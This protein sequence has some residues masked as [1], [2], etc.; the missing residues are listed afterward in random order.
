MNARNTHLSIHFV[1]GSLAV[2]LLF[3]ESTEA[4][5]KNIWLN[6]KILKQS[7]LDSTVRLKKKRS[8]IRWTH[9]RFAE[10]CGCSYSFTGW[11]DVNTVLLNCNVCWLSAEFNVRT[12]SALVNVWNMHLCRPLPSGMFSCF[13]HCQRITLKRNKIACGL[14]VM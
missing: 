9:V 14:L 3:T 7:E 6:F 13:Q 12:E 5:D 10:W 11:S 4:E 1:I 8:C 2:F